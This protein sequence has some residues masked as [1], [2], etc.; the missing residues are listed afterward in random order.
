MR[1]ATLLITVLT[2]A[3]CGLSPQLIQ[4]HPELARSADNIGQ[5]QAGRLAGG[6]QRSDQAFGTRGGVYKDTAR[7]RPAIS[8]ESGA[9]VS[10]VAVLSTT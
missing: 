5:N 4:I 9:T 3:G 1:M 2:L 6:D 8:V 10:N 7:I